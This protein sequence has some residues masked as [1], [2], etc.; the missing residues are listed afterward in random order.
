MY[1]RKLLN[2]SHQEFFFIKVYSVLFFKRSH[3]T[4]EQEDIRMQKTGVFS[5]KNEITIFDHKEE[6]LEILSG[7]HHLEAVQGFRFLGGCREQ[8]LYHVFFSF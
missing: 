7:S 6:K 4:S 8:K 2:K 5:S 3:G 1:T